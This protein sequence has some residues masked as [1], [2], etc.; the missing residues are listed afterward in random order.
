MTDVVYCTF[1]YITT[2]ENCN[3]LFYRH[4][5]GYDCQRRANLHILDSSTLI[6]VTGNL[7]HFLDTGS[8][9]LVFRRSANGCGI[10]CIAVSII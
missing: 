10:S 1:T 7:I 8:K 2:F 6:F 5:F 9:C 3:S 4:S